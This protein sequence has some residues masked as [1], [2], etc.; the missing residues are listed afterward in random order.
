MHSFKDKV[1]RGKKRKEGE[2]IVFLCQFSCPNLKMYRQCWVT[3]DQQ[4][5]NQ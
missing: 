4:F 1:R 5:E 2:K 3:T